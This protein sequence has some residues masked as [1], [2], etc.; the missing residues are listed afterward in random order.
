MKQTSNKMV[1]PKDAAEKLGIGLSTLWSKAKNQADFPKPIKIGLRTTVFYEKD[2]D[3]YIAA[4]A[5]S[6]KF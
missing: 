2:L 1:R 5:A 6:N 3:S 4:C